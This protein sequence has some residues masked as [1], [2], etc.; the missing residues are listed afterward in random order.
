M[1][2]TDLFGDDIP[3]AP[4]KAPTKDLIAFWQR[5][6]GAMNLGLATSYSRHAKV[7]AELWSRADGVKDRAEGAIAMFFDD[8]RRH[9]NL[10]P[11]VR[12][13]APKLLNYVRRVLAE[14]NARQW[15]QD[16]RREA[17]SAPR[18]ESLPPAAREEVRALASKWTAR[19]PIPKRI[20]PRD[21]EAF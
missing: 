4:K 14:G 7:M 1:T 20:D 10:T 17:E 3:E 16:E 21:D 11:D 15:R 9:P 6:E 2:G 19:K 8:C 5:Q 18:A 12:F 13:F